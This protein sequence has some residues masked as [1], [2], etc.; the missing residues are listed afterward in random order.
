MRHITVATDGSPCADR[1]VDIAATLAK[2]TG[3][4]LLVMTVGGNLSAEEVRKLAKAERSTPEALELLANQILQQASERAARAGAPCVR[5]H[6]GWGDAAETIIEAARREHSDAI[7]VGRRGRGR[8][9]GLL[10]GSVS[11]KVVALAP[12]TVVV[13]P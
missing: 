7:V 8:L 2:A 4:T 10:L 9:A 1:A 5:V 13:V 6:A 12:C 11:Q 3:A